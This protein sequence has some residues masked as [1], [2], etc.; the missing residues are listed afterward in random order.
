MYRRNLIITSPPFYPSAGSASATVRHYVAKAGTNGDSDI[1]KVTIMD[2]DN[3]L[4]SY[5]STFRH[6]VRSVF[7][8]WASTFVLE[9]SGKVS[10]SLATC[11][12]CQVSR[13][14]EH[15]TTAKLDVLYRRNL[16]NLAI[17]V[18]RS[19][20]LGD[21]GE[22]AICRRY[23]DFLYNKGDFDGAMDKFLKTIGHLQPSYVI[24]K[25]CP[26]IDAGG[27]NL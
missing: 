2:L 20:G 26:L 19:S 16:Y 27:G 9:N 13:L 14:D 24:R 12:T 25:V 22:A 10:L 11:L 17:S 5:S 15:T 23:G 8:Q 21:S 6:G 7:S 3:N 4:V 1:A 18:A